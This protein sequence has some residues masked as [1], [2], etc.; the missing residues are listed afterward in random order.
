MFLDANEELENVDPYYCAAPEILAL[1]VA[2]YRGLRK[3]DLLQVVTQKLAE[4][5]P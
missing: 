1:R 3:W 2:I 4:Y 5:E